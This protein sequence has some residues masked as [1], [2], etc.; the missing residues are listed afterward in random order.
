MHAAVAVA[1]PAGAVW[2]WIAQ[3]GQDRAG[4]YSLRRIENILYSLSDRRG[5][6]APDEV[7]EPTARRLGMLA[8]GLVVGT[9]DNFIKPIL[10]HERAEVHRIIYDELCQGA[11]R[12]GAGAGGRARG[13][14]GT[15]GTEAGRAEQPA[16]GTRY[17]RAPDSAFAASQNRTPHR[18]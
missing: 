5:G 15:Q 12:V 8:V 2:P 10:I 13:A 1:A 17:A 16:S 14:A 4:F 11:I 7:D 6:R 18:R 3:I 9:V